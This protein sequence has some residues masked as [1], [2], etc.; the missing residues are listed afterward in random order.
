MELT[1]ECARSFARGGIAGK[2]PWEPGNTEVCHGLAFGDGQGTVPAR[3][4]AEV[5]QVL[6]RIADAVNDAPQGNVV[7]GSEMRVTDLMGRN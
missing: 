2:P 4:R 5:R 3:M 1:G 6:E 7:S